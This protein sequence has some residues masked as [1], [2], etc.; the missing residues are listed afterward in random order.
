MAIRCMW[1]ACLIPKTTNTYSDYAIVIDFPLQQWLHQRA[2]VL[3]LGLVYLFIHS[4]DTLITDYNLTTKLIIYVVIYIVPNIIRI[5]YGAWCVKMCTDKIAQTIIHIL[6]PS[7]C[8]LNFTLSACKPNFAEVART[9]HMNEQAC[10]TP[11]KTWCDMTGWLRARLHDNIFFFS[12]WPL[13]NKS[14]MGIWK[15]W[16]VTRNLLGTAYIKVPKIE[17]IQ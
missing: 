9:K 13:L 14:N 7:F 6:T 8:A 12:L 4:V 10:S 17:R 15:G 1:I 11:C 5:F 3:H 16:K 2:S